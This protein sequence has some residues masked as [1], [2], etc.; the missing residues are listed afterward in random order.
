MSPNCQAIA[1]EEC[2]PV[3][4]LLGGEQGPSEMLYVSYDDS[5][6]TNP[7]VETLESAE[8]SCSFPPSS[9]LPR[10]TNTP[11]T[12]QLLSSTDNNNL[13]STSGAKE[14]PSNIP[15]PFKRAFYWPEEPTKQIAKRE[16]LPSVVTSESWREYHLNKSRQKNEK[17]EAAKTKAEERKKRKEEAEEIKK[18]KLEEKLKKQKE[19]LTKKPKVS[20]RRS[21]RRHSLSSEDEEEWQPSGDSEDEPQQEDFPEPVE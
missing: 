12:L 3:D 21:R 8:K 6:L 20:V 14:A 10:T 9:R 4:E 16:R 1:I 17:L 13:P 5:P 15:S 11:T 19:K 2:L 7:N 18:K